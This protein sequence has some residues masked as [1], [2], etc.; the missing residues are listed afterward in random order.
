MQVGLHRF[1][2]KSPGILQIRDRHHGDNA[3]DQLGPTVDYAR[4]MDKGRCGFGHRYTSWVSLRLSWLIT[5]RDIYW[6]T[7]RTS[8][9]R[10]SSMLALGCQGSPSSVASLVMPASF[11]V[12]L[13]KSARR[14]RWILACKRKSRLTCPP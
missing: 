12:T 6:S 13:A 11:A 7:D 10:E 9:G 8:C 14:D 2:E 1:G 3:G 4:W 5:N